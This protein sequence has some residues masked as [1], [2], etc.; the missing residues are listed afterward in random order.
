V[1]ADGR[2]YRIAP[3]ANYYYGPFGLLAEYVRESQ[4][5]SVGPQSL[6]HTTL[7]NDAWQVAASW[8]I[9]GEDASFKGVK[10]KRNFDIDNGGWG[11]WELVGR[12]SEL[13]IDKDA[14][15]FGNLSGT[16][17]DALAGGKFNS[18]AKFNTTLNQANHY[19]YADPKASAKSAQ[20]WTAGVNWYVNPEVKISLNYAQTSFD[21]GG[22]DLASSTGNKA[23]V[24]STFYDLVTKG[25]VRDREDERVLL[26]RF[27]IAF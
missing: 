25:K 2:R 15:Q 18:A 14:F 21:G 27:Q 22:G 3:Q 8:L 7:D 23:G 20:T 24:N 16:G 11:A 5:I 17:V 9:T 19:L 13:N 4:E 6:K 1:H 26:A 10:P 12:Y